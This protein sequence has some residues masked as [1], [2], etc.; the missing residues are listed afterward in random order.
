MARKRRLHLYTV[1]YRD[2]VTDTRLEPE[3]FYRRLPDEAVVVDIRSHAYSPF[4][5][6]YT[7]KGMEEAVRRWKSGVKTFHS[8]R[9]LGNIHKDAS[10]KHRSPPVYV[11]GEAGFAQLEA[12][13]KEYGAVVIFCVCSYSTIESETRRCHRFF[14]AEEM[15]RRLPGLKITHLR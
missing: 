15:E 2:A 7:G 11:D 5:R 1:G 14:V 8:L 12:Y 9:A 6:D 10:G 3:A 13:L 4:A